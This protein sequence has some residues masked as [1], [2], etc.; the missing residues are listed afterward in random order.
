MK[1]DN[2]HINVWSLPD[3]AKPYR[4]T[5]FVG[6][7]TAIEGDNGQSYAVTMAGKN[8][9][10]RQ[11]AAREFINAIKW[12]YAT[13]EMV[14]MRTMQETNP[15]GFEITVLTKT[16][17]AIANYMAA[18]EHSAY[19]EDLR[20]DNSAAF[21]RTGA[22]AM[23]A[24]DLLTEEFGLPSIKYTPAQ[25]ATIAINRGL[26]AEEMRSYLTAAAVAQI[27]KHTG[28]PL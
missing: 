10:C 16:H 5:F 23:E 2:L 26:V 14:A 3:S 22:A 15:Q 4:V 17:Q 18:C 24:I 6:T 13:P 11:A 8:K 12:L 27:P 21:L 28:T 7:R 20:R 9:K 19:K 1:L 25:F